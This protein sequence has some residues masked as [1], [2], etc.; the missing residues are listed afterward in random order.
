MSV[1]W[2][3][4][5]FYKPLFRM[6]R[7]SLRATIGGEYLKISCYFDNTDRTHRFFCADTNLRTQ[8]E[9]GLSRWIG[10]LDDINTDIT[11]LYDICKQDKL[12]IEESNQFK[13]IK[14][15]I[16][17][18]ERY[19]KLSSEEKS[20][21]KRLIEILLASI[22]ADSTEADSLRSK[23]EKLLNADITL[24]TISDLRLI[25]E[26]H[27]NILR[28]NPTKEII[29]KIGEFE[30]NKRTEFQELSTDILF[31]IMAPWDWYEN[32]IACRALAHKP[33]L[34]I[35]RQSSY[36]LKYQENKHKKS[37]HKKN[38]HEKNQFEKEVTEVYKLAEEEPR[39]Y[40]ETFG[41]WPPIC[42]YMRKI[43]DT[44]KSRQTYVV[45]RHWDLLDKDES[46]PPKSETAPVFP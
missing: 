15:Q 33:S 40:Q 39:Y 23:Y 22:E 20:Q 30:I 18:L 9:E 8:P 4:E 12:S 7:H 5:I 46:K 11:K 43:D 35:K 24:H 27:K 1:D 29:K 41:N 45:Y 32:G 2:K 28:N 14:K 16:I 13:H 37:K 25:K 6:Q 34:H 3:T 10:Q 38:K 31:K 44:R 36:Y 26:R 42:F 19:S 21:L 17:K